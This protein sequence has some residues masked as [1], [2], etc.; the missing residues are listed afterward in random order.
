MGGNIQPDLRDGGLAPTLRGTAGLYTCMGRPPRVDAVQFG[1]LQQDFQLNTTSWVRKR[2]ID[3]RVTAV[4]TDADQA[5]ASHV[6]ETSSECNQSLLRS[7]RQV[8]RRIE[9]PRD[10]GR[11]K[12]F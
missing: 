2:D 10:G 12:Y 5:D 8:G 1:Q 3:G 6:H 4:A 9:P 11:D 7:H